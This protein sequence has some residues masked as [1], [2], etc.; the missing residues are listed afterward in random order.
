MPKQDGSLTAVVVSGGKQY[1]VSPG[2]R[3]LVDRLDV[4]PGAEFKFDRVLMVADGDGVKVG[5][6]IVEGFSLTARV[7]G[8][9]RGPRIEVLRYKSKK[10]VRVHR[11]ARADLTAIEIIDP[12]A[13]AKA[14]PKPA[15]TA[16]K[17]AAKPARKAEPEAAEATAEAVVEAVAEA[18]PEPEAG[19][20]AAPKRRRAA[21]KE[22][23]TDGA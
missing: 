10:H 3:I 21:K 12:S 14:E 9:E 15:K 23:P 19:A 17:A 8:H 5:T 1:R 18:A 22:E 20:E 2:D 6:P 11:G 16:K 7:V 4:A 13:P